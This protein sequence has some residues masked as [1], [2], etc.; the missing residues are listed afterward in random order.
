ME[1][2]SGCMSWVL[3]ACNSGLLSHASQ[4]SG[5]WCLAEPTAG[6]LRGSLGCSTQK[7]LGLLDRLLTPGGQLLVEVLPRPAWPGVLEQKTD[8]WWPEAVMKCLV[9]CSSSCFLS[10]H[11]LNPLMQHVAWRDH[12]CLLA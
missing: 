6:H 7:A 8:L 10:G 3:G 4:D 9:S 11:P 12:F 1:S 5:K 2:W